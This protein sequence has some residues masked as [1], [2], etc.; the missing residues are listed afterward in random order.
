VICSLWT[1]ILEHIVDR[2]STWVYQEEEDGD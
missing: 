1:W 2:I